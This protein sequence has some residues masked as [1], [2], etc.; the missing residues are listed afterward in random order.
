MNYPEPLKV[1]I[2]NQDTLLEFYT[3]KEGK[4]LGIIQ[5]DMY[6]T[7]FKTNSIHYSKGDYEG[8]LLN[9]D[10]KEYYPDRQLKQKGS[11]SQG[12]KD[13][14]W[15]IWNESGTL[16]QSETWDKGNRSGYSILYDAKGM[17]LKK[18]FY[19]K[20]RFDGESIEWLSDSSYRK[21]IYK[22]GDKI[23]DTIINNKLVR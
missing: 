8:R 3:L 10:Y 21:T 12:L 15:Q 2:V 23:A 13:G 20:N 4:K 14:L 11:Y 19:K 9:G 1:R 7:W 18:V 17:L 6:Y 5:K 16:L 22:D